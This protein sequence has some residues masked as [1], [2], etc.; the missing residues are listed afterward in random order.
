V[1]AFSFNSPLN[2]ILTAFR[3]HPEMAWLTLPIDMPFVNEEIIQSLVKSRDKNKV[4]TCFYNAEGNGPE[5]LLTIW[6]PISANALLNYYEN[7][8]TSPRDFLKNA[9]VHY[10][11]IAR[12]NALISV[13]TPEEFDALTQKK[14][15][16]IQ[17][18]NPGN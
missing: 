12:H 9:D 16:N 1:D 6:E 11:R 8:K 15:N 4:A 3:L 7:G 18:I 2:G 5:P 10:V 14:S 13:N 17:K